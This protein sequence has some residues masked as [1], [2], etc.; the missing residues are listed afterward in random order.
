[1]PLRPPSTQHRPLAAHFLAMLVALH[2][3]PPAHAKQTNTFERW[4]K[5]PT[6]AVKSFAIL[7]PF[8]TTLGT[9]APPATAVH[10][11]TETLGFLAA[12]FV[13]KNVVTTSSGVTAVYARQLVHGLEVVNADVNINIKYERPDRGDW[14]AFAATDLAALS[15]AG[16]TTGKSPADVFKTLAS[17]V[18]APTPTTVNVTVPASTGITSSDWRAEI[19]SE[20]ATAPVPVQYQYVLYGNN[21]KLAYSLQLKQK[22]HWYSGH[23][24]VQSGE[25]EAVNDW[26]AAARYPVVPVGD[27]KGPIVVVD[28]AAVVL[29]NALP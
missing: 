9:I 12:E 2:A 11:L 26:A 6:L 20:N 5:V 17:F 24:N 15:D 10:Y 16:S 3:I 7:P 28:S 1:M 21:L 29:T 19:T 25:I 23:V 18:G 14:R 8:G 13:I 4:V 27:D 22:L